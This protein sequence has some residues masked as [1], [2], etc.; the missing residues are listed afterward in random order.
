MTDLSLKVRYF[1]GAAAAAGTSEQVL[2]VSG[3]STLAE[4]VTRLGED[5]P[6]LARVLS[7]A[8]FLSEGQPVS[9]R[10]LPLAQLPAPQLDV[11]P[12]FA[13]G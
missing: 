2:E 9:D 7:V 10:Q 3:E 6:D 4:V 8:S 11:L 13:G 5:N 12:P 1:A